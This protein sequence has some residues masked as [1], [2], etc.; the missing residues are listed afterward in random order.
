ML[1]DYVLDQGVIK[2]LLDVPQTVDLPNEMVTRL[3]EWV[4]SDQSE[5]LWV[6]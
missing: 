4:S 6:A 3:F 2:S 1:S 5:I